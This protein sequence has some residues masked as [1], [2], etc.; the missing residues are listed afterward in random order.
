M[1]KGKSV[2]IESR[3][4]AFQ[5]YRECGGNK[6]LTLRELEK[7]GLK[8]SKPTLYEWIEK[9]NFDGRLVKADAENQRTA[10]LQESFEKK[11]ML[12]LVGQLEKYEKYFE[13][14]TD[15]D[16]QAT[17]AYTNLLKV[18]VEISR[19]LPAKEGLPEGQ[20]KKTGLTEET[21]A[22]IK[23][24]LYGIHTNKNSAAE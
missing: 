24:E 7:K 5:T 2:F 16:N 11:M 22:K 20:V 8:L 19:R 1:T 3:E 15:I 14:N 23:E 17:Y 12:K 18:I 6:E 10:D 9:F 21:L 4:L 13:E